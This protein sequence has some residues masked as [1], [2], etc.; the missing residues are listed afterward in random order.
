VRPGDTLWGIAGR[1]LPDGATDAE[2][3]GATRA[4][5]RANRDVIGD[6]P[7]LIVPEQILEPPAAK[8]L[9]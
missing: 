1:S 7:D 3:A 9:P 2:V 6:D 8:D 4:W 5:H